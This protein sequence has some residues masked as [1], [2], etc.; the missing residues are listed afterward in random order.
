MIECSFSSIQYF[1]QGFGL[2]VSKFLED[3]WRH[4]AIGGVG[5]AVPLYI[6]RGNEQSAPGGAKK[7]A[8]P[9]ARRWRAKIR[10]V[11]RCFA[12]HSSYWLG[13][14]PRA[15]CPNSPTNEESQ[16]TEKAQN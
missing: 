1:R 13:A 14:L 6:E 9:P 16:P 4:T 3:V 2:A 12:P 7:E 15:G 8:G 5:G 10:G 11:I